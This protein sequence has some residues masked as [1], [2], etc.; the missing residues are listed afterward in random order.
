MLAASS[1]GIFMVPMLYVIFQQLRERA[2]KRFG[3]S[4]K[5]PDPP[6]SLPATSA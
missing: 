4:G 1:I 2:K 3:G 5:E 6:A